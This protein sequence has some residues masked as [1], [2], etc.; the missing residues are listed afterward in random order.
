MNFKL[1]SLEKTT[2]ITLVVGV[3]RVALLVSLLLNGSSATT[4]AR[5]NICEVR[6]DFILRSRGDSQA[7]E[8]DRLT[9]SSH[10][11]QSSST[12]KVNVTFQL[13]LEGKSQVRVFTEFC[14]VF[15]GGLM[16]EFNFKSYKKIS[17]AHLRLHQSRI[18]Q[19]SS[20]CGAETFCK[21][22]LLAPLLITRS[23]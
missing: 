7:R 4:P 18:A 20:L 19:S 1:Y 12:E 15:G 8:G 10:G 3:L 16:I 21:H 11:L 23:L 14:V 22:W 17:R 13:S 2:L 5:V 9:S 6:L